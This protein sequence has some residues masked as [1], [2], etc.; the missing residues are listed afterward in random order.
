MAA[1]RFVVG[2]AL[3]TCLVGASAGKRDGISPVE[4]VMNLIEKLMEQTKEE[5]KT[6]AAAYDKYACFCKEQ[7]DDKLYAIEKA[8]EKSALLTA[9]IKELTGAITQLNTDI[10]RMNRE[11]G[12]RE[13]KCADEQAARDKAF[14]EYVVLRDDLAGA[15]SGA[16]EA[17]VMLKEKKAPGQFLQVSEGESEQISDVMLKL[18]KAND[19]LP[20]SEQSKELVST[21]MQLGQGNAED[22]KGSEFHSDAIIDMMMDFKKKFKSH[23]NDVD[24]AENTEKH[25]FD[26][27]QAAREN[28]IKALKDN[29]EEAEKEV[30]EKEAQKESAEEDNA[31]TTQDKAMDS[32]FLDDLTTQCEAKAHLFDQRSTTR[33]AELTALSGALDVLKGEVAGNYGANKKLTGLVAVGRKTKDHKEIS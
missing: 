31:K 23:K 30:G 18:A 27:A 2:I 12:E 26:M 7:A 22:P 14:A 20:A 16:D 28:Q 8:T 29:V 33:A 5:G 11:I 25:T 24:E 4:S 10:A 9:T 3:C 15:I 21:L 17:I 32:A 1:M 6:E 13:T 19:Q